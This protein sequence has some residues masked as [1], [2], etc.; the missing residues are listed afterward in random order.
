MLTI[1]RY[2]RLRN[3]FPTTA[4]DVARLADLRRVRTFLGWESGQLHRKLTTEEVERVAKVLSL[5]ATDIADS[6]GYPLY[7]K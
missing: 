5:Q 3:G 6:N 2:E 1:A 4:L 7:V